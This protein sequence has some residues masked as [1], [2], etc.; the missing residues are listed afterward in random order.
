M[1]TAAEV[2]LADRPVAAHRRARTSL[3]P[4]PAASLH[5][6]LRRQLH[7]LCCW[8]WAVERDRRVADVR[9]ERIF[10]T[11]RDQVTAFLDPMPGAEVGA[12]GELAV[13]L[14]HMAVRMRY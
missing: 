7:R 3:L 12:P 2:V 14:S 10:R 6:W 1:R 13:H 4:T 9:L 5:R 8:R 11:Q